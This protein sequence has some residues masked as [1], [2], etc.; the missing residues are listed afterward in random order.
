MATSIVLSRAA[1]A[2]TKTFHRFCSSMISGDSTRFKRVLVVLALSQ[3]PGLAM[4]IDLQGLKLNGMAT[5]T[6][7]GKPYYIV[8]L[9]TEEDVGA[10]AGIVDTPKRAVAV[11]KLITSN[12]TPIGFSQIWTRDV[13]INNEL[14]AGSADIDVLLQFFNFPKEPL[15]AGDTIEIGFT[16]G[17]GT[18][19]ELNGDQ[20]FSTPNKALFNYLVLVWIGPSSPSREFKAEMLAG[21]EATQ[22]ARGALIERFENIDSQPQRAGLAPQWQQQDRQK[23]EQK[24]RQSTERK[25]EN[26]RV[27]AERIKQENQRRNEE[28][29]AREKADAAATAKKLAE[30]QAAAAKDASAAAERLAREA[31]EQASAKATAVRK[32]EDERKLQRLKQEE[33]KIADEGA[34]REAAE[35]ADAKLALTAAAQ[36]ERQRQKAAEEAA[37]AEEVVRAEAQAQALAEAEARR[38]ADEKLAGLKTD[39]DEAIYIWNVQRSSI[40]QISYPGWAREFGKEGSVTVLVSLDAGGNITGTEV[41]EGAQNPLLAQEVVSSINRAAPFGT[42]SGGKL[43]VP[44]TYSFHLKSSVEDKLAQAPEKPALSPELASAQQGSISK[45]DRSEILNGYIG[46]VRS[47]VLGAVEYPLW[48]RNL[49][50]EGE[51]EILITVASDG[52]VA[53]TRFVRETRHK[54]LN[55]AMATAVQKVAPFL[56]IPA[57]LADRTID[58]SVEYQFGR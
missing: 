35:R 53:A 40:A 20:L 25:A 55:N 7:L 49:R 54:L 19:V 31:S 16:P 32:R 4:A 8:G 2:A 23:A 9:Y 17:R 27:A 50:Q 28:L 43:E 22:E 18:T 24:Q 52:S 45:T 51:V 11:V 30:A 10:T 48:A 46:S 37:K 6:Q 3:T 57:E 12:W 5:Y 39:Y 38:L 15:E 47:Q 56:P 33:R 21:A 42:R 34:A 13:A 44:V 26:D 58:V 14:S 1:R 29:A 41:T 36:A